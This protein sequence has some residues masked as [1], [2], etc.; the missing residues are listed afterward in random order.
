M[1]LHGDDWKPEWDDP[2][3]KPTRWL[4]D[5]QMRLIVLAVA[6]ALVVAT[7]LRPGWPWR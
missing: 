1:E 7:A 3:R 2:R 4:S 5:R 6:I